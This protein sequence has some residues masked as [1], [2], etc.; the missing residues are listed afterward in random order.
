MA[1]ASTPKEIKQN[2]ELRAEFPPARLPGLEDGLLYWRTPEEIAADR[3]LTAWIQEMKSV[4]LS[5]EWRER[6][7]RHRAGRC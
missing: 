5:Q 4:E 6:M 2:P 1:Y 3:Q 7:L